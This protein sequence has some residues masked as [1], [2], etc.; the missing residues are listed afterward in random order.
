MRREERIRRRALELGAGVVG[1]A[2]IEDPDV[3]LDRSRLRRWLAGGLAGE[4][5]YL[6]RNETRRADPRL[7]L[8]GARSLVAVG[9]DYAFADEEA[10]RTL[11]ATG[12]RQAGAT[13]RVARYARGRDYHRVIPKKLEKLLAFIQEESPGVNG[14]IYVDTGPVLE[15]AWASR[16]G[17][18]WVGKHSLLLRQRGGSWFLLGIVLLDVELEADSPTADRC[19]SCRRCL[20]A[21]PTGA[22]VEPY[23][24]DSRLCISYL[25]IELRTA[26]PLK[27]RPLIGDYIFGC[28][29]CQD[30]CPWN[31]HAAEARLDDFRP[32]EGLLE[33]PLAAWLALDE[34]GFRRRFAGSPIARAK[35]DGFLR[36]VCVAIGNRGDQSALP[37]LR[38]TL[39]GD[40]S[41]LVRA[42]AAWALGEIGSTAAAEALREA[43][44]EQADA[45]VQGEI[46]AALERCR[47]RDPGG[48][49]PRPLRRP[50][51]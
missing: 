33:T 21:C 11:P 30:V 37:A 8:P 17:L 2:R 42:H 51:S 34:E 7:S 22:I 6:G 44:G 49:H 1:I 5:S 15:R 10:V 36:N 31:R 14:R 39:L 38:R 24:V 9:F 48:M 43:D 40:P 18:G 28:D 13:G 45:A 23:T 46:A 41:A 50:V 20:E 19:G 47:D 32:R 3:E 35:R 27:L 16:A 4:M 25:T 12:G 29:E 26:I